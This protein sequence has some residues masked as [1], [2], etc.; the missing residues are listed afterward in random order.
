MRLKH[1]G[2]EFAICAYTKGAG[3]PETPDS[4]KRRA[5][6][7]I[8]STQNKYVVVQYLDEANKYYLQWI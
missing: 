3:T 4:F 5:Y 7:L 6:W 2:E 1:N 8:N